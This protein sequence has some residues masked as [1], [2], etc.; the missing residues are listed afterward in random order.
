[1]KEKDIENYLRLQ[2]KKL[3]GLA[4]KWISPG[5]VGVPDR[6]ILM[7]NG[8]IYFVE[9]KTDK[10]KLTELQNRQLL[11]IKGMQQEVRVVYGKAGADDFIKELLDHR[12][13]GDA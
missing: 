11:K 10:G 5:N 7:P 4:Y 13:G 12:N 6:I 3:G 9:L 8:K 1:M 2:V